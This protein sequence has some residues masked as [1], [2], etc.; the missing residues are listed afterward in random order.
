MPYANAEEYL[1]ALSDGH[2][3]NTLGKR[4]PEL[5]NNLRSETGG[6]MHENEFNRAVVKY[7]D[8]ELK[9]CGFK[10]LLVAPSDADTSLKARTDLA[11]SKKAD[12][13]MS[14]HA[15]AL[16]AVWGAWGGLETLSMPS[17]KGRKFAELI[18]AEL[19]K[20]SPIRD[21]GVKDGSGLWEIRKTNMPAVL[22]EC[23]FMDNLS[24]AELLLSDAYRKECA[25]EIA[26][27]ICKG[28]N[29]QYVEEKPVLPSKDKGEAGKMVVVTYAGREG[30]NIRIKPDFTSTVA[31]VAKEGEA[32]TIVE[33]LADHYKIK[34]GLYITKAPEYVKVK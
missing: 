28:F 8:A 15:N 17:G 10:T 5:P 26:R 18:H 34:S 1:I 9:R 16:H 21:R 19:M 12:L 25:K 31:Y 29:V 4:T 7:L 13:Y 24:E 2:G 14:V 32:F 30:L 27:G 33:E 22:A 3:M 23:G 6:F 20:G 11:N